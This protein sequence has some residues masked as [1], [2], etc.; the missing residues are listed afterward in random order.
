MVQLERLGFSRQAL[1]RVLLDN[2][3][4]RWDQQF[5]GLQTTYGPTPVPRREYV[6]L[7][8]R[9][10][11]ARR[12]ELR[13]ALGEAGYEAWRQGQTL[14]ELNYARPPGDLLSMSAEE[15]NQA[16][17]LQQAFDQQSQDL[18]MA[19]EDG[20][21]DSADANSLRAR[22]QQALDQQLE[23]LLGQERFNALRGNLDAAANENGAR[24][25]D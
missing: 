12:R 2:F 3:N 17:R 18:Q 9:R 15:A 23:Q 22:A 13:A 8:R 24:G 10:D 19:M 6:L 5:A 16:C 20:V 4:R 25:R 11:A 7:A 1:A 21:A 14:A